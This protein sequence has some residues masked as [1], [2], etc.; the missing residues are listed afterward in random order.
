M[1]YGAFPLKL[2]S[3]LWKFRIFSRFGGLADIIIGVGYGVDEC[4][5]SSQD[6]LL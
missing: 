5:L 4:P 2:N 3:S 6:G 1:I